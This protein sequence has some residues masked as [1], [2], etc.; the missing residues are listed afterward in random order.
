MSFAPATLDVISPNCG[1]LLKQVVCD[2]H[3]QVANKCA[4]LDQAGLELRND[5]ALRK[6]LLNNFGAALTRHREE[7]TRAIVEE[8]GKLPR[9]AQGEFDYA[10][11]FVQHAVELSNKTSDREVPAS[12]RK[13]IE[14]V[15][16]GATLLIT[17]YND[18]VA[19]I[20]RK[21]CPAIAAGCPVLLQPSPL[22]CIC[23]EIVRECFEEAGGTKYARWYTAVGGEA[24]DLVMGMP[25]VATVSFTGS[26]EVGRAVA[27]NAGR[28]LVRPILELGGNGVMVVL[29]DADI[30]R[31]AHDAVA[32]KTKA[33]GQAC[34]AVNRVWVAQDVADD[35]RQ[36][37]IE[38]ARRVKAGSALA[39]D[40]KMGPV[41]T[42]QHFARLRKLLVACLERDEE[43]LSGWVPALP[44]HGEPLAFPLCV[45]SKKSDSKSPL[46]DEESF[47]PVLGIREIASFGDAIEALKHERKP[48]VSYIY[49]N[50]EAAQERFLTTLHFG[51]VGINTTDIQGASRPTGGFREAGYGREGGGYGMDEFRTTINISTESPQKRQVTK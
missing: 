18:P 30:E 7:L 14:V 43:L 38:H 42:A 12:G 4:R 28:H 20:V 24:A 2:S 29:A 48:L 40:S 15:G 5:P 46:D 50:D 44:D 10:M 17:P 34:S 37:V 31:A 27:I 25:E 32:R 6:G 26:T 9:E 21:L 49:T 45:T 22:G 23:S 3:N 8:V 16:R 47:G 35:F 33:A 19:G 41:R 1:A 39:E 51:S 13:C 11:S 36:A